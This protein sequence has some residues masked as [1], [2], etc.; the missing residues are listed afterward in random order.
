MT[1]PSRSFAKISAQ[2]TALIA[3]SAGFVALLELAGLPAAFLLGPMIAAIFIATNGGTI[4][5][6]RPTLFFAQT[7][8][9]C[10]V[11]RA[12]TPEIIGTFSYAWPLILGMA[13]A[14][15][16][17]STF[18]GWL[19]ARLNVLPGTTAIWGTAPG[20]ASAMMLMSAEFGADPRMVAFMQYLRVVIVAAV[21]SLLARFWIHIGAAAH[22]A[23]AWFPP[24][25]WIAFGETLVLA[26]GGGLLGRWLKLPAGGLL[27][28]MT[29][30][31]LLHGTGLMK[32]EL[33]QWLLAAS[34]AFLG[35]N[36]GLGFTREILKHA[37][38]ALPQTLLSIFALIAFSA[39]LALVLVKTMNVDPLTAYLGTSPGGMD[40]VAIIAAST[41]V[42]VSFVMA[43]QTM[44]FLIVLLAG[45]PLARFV[46]SRLHRTRKRKFAP[47]EKKGLQKVRQKVRQDEPELD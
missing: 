47:G 33:P 18:L 27:V 19:L 13:A 9:G 31:A 25:D 36:I 11:A 28:P 42:N 6:F 39:I 15:L 43:L 8:I 17:M 4:R 41:P 2:W 20:A 34:Y 23:I 10:L 40:S 16:A 44:R 1:F 5:I 12:I 3:L 46:A 37:A 14:I 30:G 45:P 21:A 32:I 38:R 24:V 26:I 22:P 29:V 35:W 7:I